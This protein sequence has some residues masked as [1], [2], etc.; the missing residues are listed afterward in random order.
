MTVLPQILSSPPIT[1]PITALATTCDA[2]PIVPVPFQLSAD[3]YDSIASARPCPFGSSSWNTRRGVWLSFMGTGSNVTVHTCYDIGTLQ[4]MVFGYWSQT[5]NC[6]TCSCFAQCNSYSSSFYLNRR[7]GLV[8]FYSTDP[9]TRYYAWIGQYSTSVTTGTFTV[10]VEPGIVSPFA[11]APVYQP[12]PGVAPPPL[13]VSPP[14]ARPI[15]YGTSMC[16][17]GAVSI[18]SIPRDISMTTT[19]GSF[20]DSSCGVY[21]SSRG[22][23]YSYF[24]YKNATDLIATTCSSANKL[25]T[26]L[27]VYKSPCYGDSLFDSCNCATCISHNDDLTDGLTP[28]YATAPNVDACSSLASQVRFTATEGMTYW[29]FV[30]AD[31][32]S[33]RTQVVFR[34]L[35]A[36][37][38]TAEAIAARQKVALGLGFGIT[39]GLIAL[40]IG[41]IGFVCWSRRNA[42]ERA[43]ARAAAAPP[44]GPNAVAM[45]PPAKAEEDSVEESDLKKSAAA[46]EESDTSSDDGSET[47]ESEET[48]EASKWSNAAAAEDSESVSGTADKKGFR[49]MRKKRG[50]KTAEK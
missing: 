33:S 17:V 4:T 29:F 26:E 14:T 37:D 12:I 18:T 40:I 7:C 19:I 49:K 6:T 3:N 2:A 13:Y 45:V 44:P 48:K 42:R 31:T 43:A 24:H 22:R 36:S 8:S 10:H 47:E 38:Y 9:S 35:L 46:K 25:D 20:S 39:L 50:S 32:A 28:A 5:P 15:S 1:P 41:I 16:T 27:S 34:L 30:K 23:W 21:S 11:P